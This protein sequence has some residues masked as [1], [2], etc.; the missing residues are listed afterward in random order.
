M[1]K[2]IKIM[3]FFHLFYSIRLLKSSRHPVPAFLSVYVV[4][5]GLCEI[6]DL[7]VDTYMSYKHAASVLESKLSGMKVRSVYVSRM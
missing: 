6:L 3:I 4:T 2:E 7:R 5:Y 1:L